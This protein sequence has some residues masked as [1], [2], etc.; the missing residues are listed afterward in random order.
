MSNNAVYELVTQ[1]VVSL[2]ESGVIP[3][4]KPWITAELDGNN[5][6]RNAVSKR[7]Y[8]GINSFLLGLSPYADP[9]WLTFKQAKELG[10]FV[11]SG[12]KASP[13]VFWKWLEIED[14]ETGEKKDIPFLRYYSVFNVEQTEGCKVAELPK[15]EK[16]CLASRLE[17]AENVVSG[18]PNA[19]AIYHDGGSA[20]YYRPSNDTVH[21]PELEYFLSTEGYYSTLFHELGHSTGH[22]TRLNRPGITELASFGSEKYSKEELVAEFTAAFLTNHCGIDNH[23]PQNAAYI[24]SWLS[25]LKKDVKMAVIAAAQAQ[26]AA[27]YILGAAYEEEVGEAA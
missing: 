17:A 14:E 12:E 5:I 1:R 27:D 20:A 19:P 10:G 7:R 6:P 4:R 22:E 11:K 8:R 18:M 2:L 26:K 15:V 9:R 13:V 24:D 25:A 21:M 3:W 16:P 23:I